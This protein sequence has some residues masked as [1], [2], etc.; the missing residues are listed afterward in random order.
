VSTHSEATK[1]NLKNDTD[2]EGK[3]SAGVRVEVEKD[4]VGAGDRGG[5]DRV[6]TRSEEKEKKAVSASTSTSLD[7]SSPV[8]RR[9]TPRKTAN[10]KL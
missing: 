5:G 3:R 9:S 6:N 10:K 2:K 4:A 8:K 7:T 1:S